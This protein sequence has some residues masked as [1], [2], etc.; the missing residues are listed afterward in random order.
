MERNE[1]VVKEKTSSQIY[2]CDSVEDVS[3]LDRKS[4]PAEKWHAI[5]Q[6]QKLDTRYNWMILFFFV[7]WGAF[8]LLLTVSPHFAVDVISYFMMGC[9]VVG[10]P[11]L[12]HESCHSILH[13]N[14]RL[15]RLL[16]FISGIPGLVSVSAYRSIHLIHHGHT[17]TPED[18]DDIVHTSPRSFPAVLVYYLVLFIGIYIYIPTVAITG[19]K[20]ANSEYKR[21][22]LVEYALMFA[23]YTI[24]LAVVPFE[25]V[26]KFWIIPLLIAG[27]LSNV[28]GLAEHGLMSTGNEF[29]DTR[30]V[31][32]NPFVSLM[33]CNLNY[34]LEHHLFPGI[35]W[36]NLPKI[37]ELLKEEFRAAGSSVYRSYMAFMWDFVLTTWKKRIVPEVR[38]I[39]AHIRDEVCA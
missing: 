16:G 1:G 22:I 23:I 36:Y 34:H 32:S 17:R 18:P 2:F 31:I 30:T 28:R 12:M 8:G 27:Q 5:R 7:Q 4:L 3:V 38:L 15:N 14:L 21:K 37:H 10:L 24:V 11:V 6:L 13:K 29:I 20:K 35:P 19:Y 39:P 33:M 25:A 26:L 9:S